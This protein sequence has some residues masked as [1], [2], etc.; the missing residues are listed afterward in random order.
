MEIK[1]AGAVLDFP[2]SWTLATSETISTST[3]TV[4]PAEAGGVTTSAAAVAGA[5]TSCLLSGG[6]YRRV[7]TVTDRITTNQ[8]RTLEQTVTLRIGPSEVTG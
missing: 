1:A 4:V 7:Y 5:V 2:I 8:G 3:W 6:I